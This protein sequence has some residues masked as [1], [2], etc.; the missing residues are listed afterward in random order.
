MCVC[1]K[2]QSPAKNHFLYNSLRMDGETFRVR[3]VGGWKVK[4]I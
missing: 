3:L 2:V 1:V 4:R